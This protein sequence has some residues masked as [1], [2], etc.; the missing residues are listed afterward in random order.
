MA[1]TVSE[2]RVPYPPG[3]Y[4]EPQ[5]G[6]QLA[7]IRLKTC[8]SEDADTNAYDYLSA[9]VTEWSF[10]DAAGNSYTGNSGWN[11]W[12]SPRY[13]ELRGM[14]AGECLQ[15]WITMEIPKG[16]RPTRLEYVPLDGPGVIAEWIL[17]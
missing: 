9:S 2:V 10:R 5:A 3:Q 12:P 4:R 14:A 1:T 13:P 16:V 17:P 7:G 11:D 6:K 8:V 15:G